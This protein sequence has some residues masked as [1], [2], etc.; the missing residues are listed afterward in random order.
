MSCL[1]GIVEMVC[2]AVGGIASTCKLFCY[3][4]FDY[5]FKLES[6]GKTRRINQRGKSRIRRMRRRGQTVRQSGC[7][8]KIYTNRLVIEE[9]DGYGTIR[10]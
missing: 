1:V 2:A 3:F 4:K 5:F 8:S 6:S 10:H 7:G 9:M